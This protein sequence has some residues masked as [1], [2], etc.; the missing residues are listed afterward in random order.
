MT[1]KIVLP[2]ALVAAALVGVPLAE[3][4]PSTGAPANA[5][6]PAAKA[7]A[8]RPKTHYIAFSDRVGGKDIAAL[9]KSNVSLGQAIGA[10]ERDT[11]GKA[12]EAVF[13][14]AP[15]QPHY[16]VWVMENGRVLA[17]G[18][19]A[20]SGTVTR[21]G[22]GVPLHRLVP[23]E[24]AEF[25]ITGKEPLSLGGA[26]AIAQKDSG[27]APIAASLERSDRT[28]GYEVAL[29]DKGALATVWVSPDNPTMTT[30]R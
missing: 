7:P 19:D 4:A 24:R 3:A 6:Q 11:H 21:L 22:R 28:R 23:G 12:V 16:V 10:A 5:A 15:D 29:V 26:V 25:R 8:A 2:A 13:K 18:V 14:A 17:A 30:S 1:R 9:A 27:N 20:R